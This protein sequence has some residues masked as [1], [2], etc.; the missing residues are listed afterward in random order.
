MGNGGLARIKYFRGQML[1]ARDFDDQQEYHRQKQKQLLRRFPFGIVGGLNVTCVQKG[2]EPDD[3][4]GFLIEEGLAIDRAGNEI[5]VPEGGFKVPVTEFNS[6]AP[7]LSLVYTED[8]VLVGDALCESNQKNNRIEEGFEIRWEMVPNIGDSITVALIQ[9]VDPNESGPICANYAVFEEDVAG[10]PRIRIDAGVVGTE[11]LAD[12]SVTVDKIGNSAVTDNKIATS[13]V[14][15]S[16]IQNNAVSEGKIQTGAVTESKI[17]ANA[18]TAGKI[19]SGAV[20]AEK[21]ANGAVTGEKI[22]DGAVTT[23]KIANGAVTTEKIANGAVVTEKIADGAVTSAK[24]GNNAVTA[25]KID[26]AA[27]VIEKIRD[28][29][30][31]AEKIAN[32]AVTGEKIANGAVTTEK[33]ANGAVTGEKIANGAVTGEKIADGAVT[34]EKIADGAVT[35]EKIA[36]RAV[37]SG[38]IGNNAVTVDKIDDAAV[39]ENK[40]GNSAVTSDKIANEAVTT[41]KIADL[42]VTEAKL[43]QDV[44]AKLNGVVVRRLAGNT[45]SADETREVSISGI[46]PNAIIH[47][48]PTSGALSWTYKMSA[49][50]ELLDYT[51]AIKNGQPNDITEY[52]IRSITF[53]N[54]VTQG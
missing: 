35:A 3:F 8:E 26:D 53:N 30:V 7:Y 50:G 31:I 24:I 51:I 46:P 45:L 19:A 6:E 41:D 1:T 54:I 32:G 2:S 22:A 38:K 47:V 21:I 4:D 39:A 16:K 49:S 25:D 36:D 48:V 44:Q 18:V 33:I 42:A 10:G 5:T 27:V 12:G 34:T 17:G 20:T 23:E 52:E 43:S 11:Q 9:L 28:G 37:T 14:T 13:A 40:I 15:E 29:A